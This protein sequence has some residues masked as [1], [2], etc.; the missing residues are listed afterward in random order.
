MIDAG[1]G[2]DIVTVDGNVVLASLQGGEEAIG[3]T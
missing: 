3:C 1:T 2:N